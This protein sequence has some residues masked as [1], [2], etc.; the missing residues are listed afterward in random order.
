MW[1]TIVMW[2]LV[3]WYTIVMW[4]Y[5]LIH[6]C[7]V[8]FVGTWEALPDWSRP[9]TW[10]TII[11]WDLS[12]DTQLL[13]EIWG[14]WE[15]LPDWSMPVTWYT[16]VMWDLETW[17]ALPDW[18]R[19]LTSDWLIPGKVSLFGPC[20]VH[21]QNLGWAGWSISHFSTQHSTTSHLL[22][23]H[24]LT[25]TLHITKAKYTVTTTTPHY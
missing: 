17:E 18:S 21:T 12:P 4:D 13:C 15:A 14:T 2:D 16:N 5:H 1:C 3:T 25:S 24:F 11:M 8:R 20:K 22:Y 7:Y 10:Y 19:I 6:N 23:Y 9:V